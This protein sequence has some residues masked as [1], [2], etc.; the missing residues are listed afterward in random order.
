[1][2]TDESLLAPE[3]GSETPDRVTCES[4]G[5]G[6]RLHSLGRVA[7]KAG[8]PQP[9][10]EVRPGALERRVVAGVLIQALAL[11]VEDVPAQQ[12]GAAPSAHGGLAYSELSGDFGLSQQA[13]LPQSMVALAQAVA[14][15]KLLDLDGG[16]GQAGTRDAFATVQLVRDFPGREAVEQCVDFGDHLRIGAPQVAGAWRTGHGQ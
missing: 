14:G 4:E 5:L 10:R 16:E 11:V 1:M 13:L 8:W 7:N 15:A 12:A 6:I 2:E 3:L 9:L